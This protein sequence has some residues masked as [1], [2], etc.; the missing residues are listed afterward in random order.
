MAAQH[1][2]STNPYLARFADEPALVAPGRRDEF[3][4]CLAAL[5]GDAS[6]RAAMAERA[7]A[8]GD[9]FWDIA[10]YYRPYVVAD[11]ILTIPVRGV[12]LNDFPYQYGS[13][14]TGY[15]YIAKAIERGLGDSD[16]KGIA[17]VI[18][19]PGGE[20]AGNFDLVDAIYAARGQKPIRAFAA[21]AAYSAAYSI[22]SA[23]ERI[24]LPRTGGVGSIGVVTSH[25]D[26]S[27]AYD[28][29]GF[30]VTFI[31][32][33]AHKVDGNSYEPLPPAVKARIQERIDALYDVF[34]STVAR[35]RGLDEQAVRDTEALTFMAPEALAKGLAD[36]IGSL[37]SSLAAFA[38]DVLNPDEGDETMSDTKPAMT[39]ASAKA[40]YPDVA[41][42]LIAEGRAAA[43][44]EGK[45][46]TEAAVAEAVAKERSRG[47]GLDE[48]A[49]KM[50]NHKE[51]AAIVAAAKADG[52]TVEATAVKLIQSGAAGKAAIVTG[53]ERDDA[54][55]GGARPASPGATGQVPQTA[56]GWTAEW[57]ASEALQAEFALAS[58]YVGFRMHEA[59]QKGTK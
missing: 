50:G 44:A 31:Y 58:D 37:D 5:A 11:G 3:E 18:N 8:G 39:V 55:A 12:L 10:Q 42:A 26:L 48:L 16:V 14:A 27:K 7:A 52:S 35:N 45:T 34:V 54:S 40:D 33:G 25:L 49:E 20:V 13:W 9:P 4:S 15:G 32:A 38:A 41:S 30:K 22:A 28:E 24:S 56:A 46:K 2:A 19:S 53:L 21:E 23:A 47:A 59:K 57:E 29:I 36:A 6:L 51:V 17:L 43:E 1:S